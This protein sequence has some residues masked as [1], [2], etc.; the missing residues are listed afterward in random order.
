MASLT[1]L[2]GTLG[3]RLA[4]HLLRRTTYRYTKQRIQQLAAMTADQAVEDLLTA[5]PL[6]LEQPVYDDPNTPTKE[7]IQWLLPTNQT[8]P[9][10]EFPLRQRVIG[11]WLHNA[12]HD[13]SI[14]HK[15]AFFFHQYMA[16]SIIAYNHTTFFDYLRLLRWGSLGNFKKLATKMVA[17]NT[18]LIYLN[19]HQNS[20][21][22]PNENFA[23][24]FFELF[25][26][27]KGPQIGP[28]DYTNYTEDD[29]V[30]AARVFTGWR[31]QQTRTNLDPETGFPR[32]TAVISRHDTGSK[33]F[34]SK[35][36]N[37]VIPGATTA[38]GMYTELDSFVNMVF[39]QDAPSLTLVRR[40]YR[41][42]VHPQISPEAEQDIIEPL[43]LLLRTN[44][45]E[46]MPVLRKLLKSQHFFDKDD[47][48]HGDEI[49]GGI[50]RSP[51]DM[52]LQSISFFDIAIP[53]ALEQNNT[54]YI[55]FYYAGVYER[56]CGLANLN[57]FFP[58]DVAGYP[59]YYQ[60][61]DFSRHW[62][63]STSVIARYKLPQMLLTGKRVVGSSPNSSIGIKLDIV[64]WVR[65]NGVTIDPSNA[66]MLVKDLLDYLLPLK[67]DNERFLYFYDQVFLDGLPAYDWTYEWEKYLQTNNQTEVK[68]MLERLINAIMFSQEFQT[69]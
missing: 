32:G 61:P 47:S 48:V 20:K 60:Y 52:A 42:F 17:D 56:M 36:Q 50:I 46:I 7:Y 25:T 37:T 44:N 66:Y 11:W 3:K 63:S 14:G 13:E 19:G 18:M 34:S 40:L 30:Q 43:A 59:A 23:R 21:T 28:N 22:S 12:L 65:N 35:F 16:T 39:A 57:L 2:Q 26:S 1:P 51:L 55:T 4:A 38:D 6:Q 53:N 10:Q 41:Y 5:R 29:I 9:A 58:P 69:A 49:I 54:H 8:L 33:T 64:P 67:V 68:L 31:L 27:G 24:E 15:M 45:Y 62:F